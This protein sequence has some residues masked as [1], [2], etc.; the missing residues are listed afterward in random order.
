MRTRR[1][2]GM[3]SGTSA[4]GVDVA[5]IETDG[6]DYVMAIAEHFRPYTVEERNAIRRAYAEA[7]GLKSGD[8]WPEALRE[9]AQILTDA[10]AAAAL[11]LLDQAGREA[12]G[13]ELVGFHGQTVLHDPAR[14]F[15]LQ[16]GLPE[17]LA[18][19]CGID[20][21]HDFR[22]ADVAAGGQ[23][24]PLVPLYH[25][26]RVA[27]LDK[28]LAILN[29]GGVANVTHIGADGVPLAFDTGPGNALIDDWVHR[30]AGLAHDEG[31]AL[32]ARGQIDEGVLAILMDH[33]YFAAPPPKSLDR[34]DFSAAPAEGLSLE[35]GAATLT[36]FTAAA[37]AAARVHLPE[38]PR[39]WL[40][41]GGGRHNPT[42]MAD[43]ARRLNAP[44]EPVEA[45]GLKGDTLEAE[46]FAYLAV[47]SVEG[48]PLSLPTTTGVA[49]P[50][51]GGRL[52]RV[53][54]VPETGG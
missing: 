46:A 54:S 5:L 20:V 2:I 27:H 41:A 35:D 13:V 21:V 24:A 1:A 28:P 32:A 16:I 38:A 50:L 43:L 47:R 7:R 51:S 52:T 15:T 9:A 40:I 26:A 30:H 33:P 25:A 11:T 12:D 6:E 44:V 48:L 29:I 8:P 14:R 53:G 36:A 34:N 22:S 10:H 19:A 31:G 39:R 45:A 3:M 18:A 17:R 49:E 23:G 37:V 42:L 4:D